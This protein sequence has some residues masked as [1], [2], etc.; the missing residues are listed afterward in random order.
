M[1]QRPMAQPPAGAK[2]PAMAIHNPRELGAIFQDDHL[3]VR[4]W[5]PFAGR[6]ALV[7]EFN[8]WHGDA[9][10]LSPSDD[11]IWSITIDG[12]RPG[13]HYQLEITYEGQTFRKND[14]YARR[15]DRTSKLAVLQRDDFVWQHDAITLDRSDLVIYELHVGTFNRHDT[16]R[17]GTFQGIIER[18]PYLRE[19]GVSAIELMPVS[20]FP[21]DL[22]WGYNT[23][24]PFAIEE[25]YGGPDGLRAL[26]DAAHGHGLGVI[27]D[28]TYNHLGP[29]DLDLW[30]FDG[31]HDNDLGG[32]YFYNDHRASTPWGD[33]RPDYGRP[34][35]RQYLRDNALMWFEDFRVDGLRLDGTKYV[36]DATGQDQSP[37]TELPE[38]WSLM[39]W[40]ND[41]IHAHFPGA[42]TLAE[43]MADN[44]AL[45]RATADGGAGFDAQWDVG[46]VHPVRAAL[47]APDDDARSVT[48]VAQAIAG[49]SGEAHMQRVVYTESHDETANGRARL[50]TEITP[51]DPASLWA[52]RRSMLGATLAFTTPGIAMIFEGQEILED[53]WFRD[54]V[55]VDWSKLE[56]FPEVHRFYRRLIRLRRDRDGAR[57]LQGPHLNLFHVD[58]EAKVLAYHRY[59]EGGPGDDVVVVASFLAAERSVRIGLPRAG[60][61]CVRSGETDVTTLQAEDAAWDGMPASIEVALGGYGALVLTS[62]G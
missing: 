51:D 57:G 43:D 17:P 16:H 41:E 26:V 8:D 29:A 2:L 42:L 11:G 28:V 37:E 10:V 14:P 4:V 13:Q 15:I 22:S 25:S 27:V 59:S 58:D 60:Q 38:G 48:A 31:W 49:I 18:L 5:A 1:K 24:N 35:V 3:T 54:D 9:N 20:A 21:T 50:P 56:A 19:L 30:R 34:E 40:L 44:A 52:Q 32:I 6:V 12:A 36:R 47:E 33:N 7:G 23:T 61:W 55:A 53:G 46:F 45:T 39:Q 62:S